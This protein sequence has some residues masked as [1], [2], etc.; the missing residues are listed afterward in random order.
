MVPFL[1]MFLNACSS[2]QYL[3]QAGRGQLALMNRGKPIEQV[4][5]DPTTDPR[6]VRLLSRIA[7]IRNFCV[8]SG[9]RE[10]P[11]YREYVKLDRDAVVYVVTVSE[12]LEFKVKIFSFPIA[13]SFNYIGWFSKDDAVKFGRRFR[14][15]G[16]DVD[17]RGA[18]AYSTL[19]WF[20]DPLLSTM[21]PTED[22]II[23]EDAFAELVNVVIHESVHATL[24]LDHQSYFNESL[25]VFIADEL[26]RR[27][28]ESRKLTH[29]SEWKSYLSQE[30]IQ[31]KR[32]ERLLKA[33][34]ELSALYGSS[35][36]DA[37][38]QEK[39]ERYLE[40]LRK[41][42]GFKRPINNATLI[43]VKTYH[44][45]D[46]GF[47][48]L[49]RET[50]SDLRKFLNRLATLQSDDFPEDQAEVFNVVELLRKRK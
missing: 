39:K 44:D 8:E 30:G 9:L 28:F 35:M 2:I 29:S 46:H 24:Y 14:E 26:T 22:G 13:G 7:D 50:G 4:I 45:G 33:Y 31:R 6:L 36:T 41:E 16:K 25:A 19:G 34:D 47:A 12:A 21:I 27:Y 48:D 3:Y 43:Q 37:E 49:Y 5:A 38:K 42:V 1:A 11:N 17:I 20:K 23:Q 15:E 40:A 10:T 32:R 18:S